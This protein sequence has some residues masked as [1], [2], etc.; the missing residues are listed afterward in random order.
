M[1][2]LISLIHK[3]SGFGGHF[4]PVMSLEVEQYMEREGH[5]KYEAFGILFLSSF[6]TPVTLSMKS[7]IFTFLKEYIYIYEYISYLVS[8]VQFNPS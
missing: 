6:H 7:E 8:E 3:I 4:D 5:R 2:S 1:R